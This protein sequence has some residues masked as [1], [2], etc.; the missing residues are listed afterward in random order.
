VRLVL[1]ERGASFWNQLK[2]ASP[3]TADDELLAAL[4]DLVWAGEVTNDT[5][6]PLRAVLAGSRVRTT[7]SRASVAKPGQRIRPR[8]GRLT[9]IGPPAGAGRWSLVA[10]LLEPRPSPTE[11]AHA[12]ALQLVERHGVVTREAVLAEGVVGGYAA[13][14]GVLKVLEERGQVRRGYFVSGL[15]AAQFALPGAVDRLRVVRERADEA[16]GSTGAITARSCSPPP[17]RRSPTAPRWPGRSRPAVRRAR[18]RRWSC[19]A[20]GCRSPGTTAARTTSSRSPTPSMIG[21]G[22]KRWPTSCGPE[23]C[24]GSRS[25]RSMVGRCRRRR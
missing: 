23:G 1:A 20:T 21:R 24:V 16:I 25:A 2:A 18:R 9:R 14:Y 8:P 15:G 10:P 19:S 13:V 12:M 7:Q 3:G 11:A 5:L 22:P 6:G 17:T 4:W